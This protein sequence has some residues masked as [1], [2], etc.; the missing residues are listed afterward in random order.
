M[1][2][3]MIAPTPRLDYPRVVARFER[4]QTTHL[5][6]KANDI[7]LSEQGARLYAAAI[8]GPGLRVEIKRIRGSRSYKRKAMISLACTADRRVKLIALVHEC[9]HQL[10]YR[11]GR[12]AD[13]PHGESF[14]LTYQRLL[15][16]VLGASS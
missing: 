16:E 6:E 1:E 8:C 13:G 3:E 10:N 11:K 7:S 4:W 14:C 12:L 15:R 9:A 5:L 2:L